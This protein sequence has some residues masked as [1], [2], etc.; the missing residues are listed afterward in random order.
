MRQ[1]V[2]LSLLLAI[3]GP[4]FAQAPAAE[5]PLLYDGPGPRDFVSPQPVTVVAPDGK[6][7]IYDA[8]PMARRLDITSPKPAAAVPV[9]VP[10]PEKAAEPPKPPPPRK[11]FG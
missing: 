10:A 6:P 2:F 7:F 11:G 5:K 9:P 4:A 3:A 8:A 1:T